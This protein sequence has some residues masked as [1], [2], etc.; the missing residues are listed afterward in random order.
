MK[1]TIPTWLVFF[2]LGIASFAP[3]VNVRP[4]WWALYYGALLMCWV[5]VSVAAMCRMAREDQNPERRLAR[6]R[7]QPRDAKN[8][9]LAETGAAPS[10]DPL[11]E[12][13]RLAS[14]G[15]QL[16]EPKSAE[17]AEKGAAPA[18]D[19]LDEER[20]LASVGRELR[21]AKNAE[22]AETGAVPARDP[23]DAGRLIIVA[24]DQASLYDYIRR[25]QSGNQTISVITDRRRADR[26]H[27]IE[28][29]VP[30]RRRGERRRHDIERVLLAQGWA[31]VTL[32][33]S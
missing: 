9:E 8:A 18:R 11:D 32:P 26:R 24:R 25:R 4:R 2:F 23:L 20:R 29:H 19:P 13:R 10:R 14:V 30:D 27:G 31:Q 7:R 33:K 15:R 28:A 22:P 6:V 21:D 1:L 5:L 17:P 12:E 3:I 16:R